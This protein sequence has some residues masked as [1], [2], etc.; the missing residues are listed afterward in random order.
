MSLSKLVSLDLE[1]HLITDT[2]LAPKPVC[3]T[4]NV[5]GEEP[6]I[7]LASEI[8]SLLLT[9]T[10]NSDN[11]TLVLANAPF[12]MAVI[13]KHFPDYKETVFRL[14]NEG[15]IRDVQI[16]EKLLDIR[17]G[18][19]DNRKYDLA[20][21]AKKYLSLELDKSEDSWRKRYSELDGV[22]LKDWPEA[23]R[24]Y[25]LAD[26]SS[27]LRV[28][29]AQLALGVDLTAQ[30]QAQCRAHFALHLSSVKGMVTD[31]VATAK[32]KDAL[33]LDLTAK[34]NEL[35]QTDLFHRWPTTNKRGIHP[36]AGQL[37]LNSK[38]GRP[39]MNTKV[40]KAK[41]EAA[42]AA[43]GMQAP[44][45]EKGATQYGEEVLRDAHDPLLEALADT[46]Y[47]NKLL[48]TFIPVLERGQVHAV[49]NPL[50]RTGRTSSFR[51]NIQNLPR[52]GGIR[53]CFIPRE[54]HVFISCDYAAA[55]L[56]ALAQIHY[57]M[58]GQSTMRDVFITGRD[59][60]LMMAAQ[61]AGTTYEDA[62]A[63][64][65][66]K[67]PEIKKLRQFAKIANFGLPGG[68][69]TSTFVKHAKS[70]GITIS[71]LE[72]ETIKAA[73]LQTWPE[74]SAYFQRAAE[75][76]GD[77]G[78]HMLRHWITG[79]EKGGCGYSEYCNAQFQGLIA[80]GAKE[81][82]WA[83]SNKCHLSSGPLMGSYPVAFLHDEILIEAPQDNASA[84]GDEL[85]RVMNEVMAQYIP[86][87]PIESSPAMMTRWY[88]D[89]DTVRDENGKLI[90]WTPNIR[91]ITSHSE[92]SS[93]KAETPAT[94]TKE[95]P[96]GARRFYLTLTSKTS[97]TL[98]EP[99][100]NSQTDLVTSSVN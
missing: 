51:P 21:L 46:S 19:T 6:R 62:H 25:P 81:A 45:T 1:T 77:F 7:A 100:S 34:Q 15:R 9:L 59:P 73:W 98:T 96:T 70:N 28:Y 20:T 5:A 88:K 10:F 29:E 95:T 48:N 27:T 52:K 76:C 42:Y 86:D 17:A 44:K 65:I 12:D 94:N 36:K 16:T 38:T 69:G 71:L 24:L 55:E 85:S 78:S 32:L 37:K 13:A 61:L 92:P 97:E 2:D 23:A 89:A 26:A 56:R 54:G 47:G 18:T 72:A 14:Y 43:M 60:H 11:H 82:Y 91:P 74:M 49:Y 79:R 68:M 31:P 39:C 33:L 66:S 4:W 63:R 80:D 64:H 93:P 8:P 3:V 40:L 41:V 35:Y 90:L 84:A 53:E 30:E 58:F 99:S 67:D 75:V 57:W 83:V 22:P 87:V 50:V